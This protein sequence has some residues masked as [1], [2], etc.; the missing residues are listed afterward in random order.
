MNGRKERPAA[1]RSPNGMRFVRCRALHAVP[2]EHRSKRQAG[3]AHA[4]IGEE[5]PARKASTLATVVRR[6]A[7][8]G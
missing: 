5:S 7:H 6:R 3:E 8:D 1:G 2:P 4:D